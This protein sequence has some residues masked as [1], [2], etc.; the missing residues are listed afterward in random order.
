MKIGSTEKMNFYCH[1][2]PLI[3]CKIILVTEV[4]I[5]LEIDHNFQIVFVINEDNDGR[6]VFLLL[7]CIY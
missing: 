6:V 3:P 7:N 4:D 5:C 2:V 1:Y